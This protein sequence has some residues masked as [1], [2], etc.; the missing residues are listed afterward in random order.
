ML[1]VNP[2]ALAFIIEKAREFD[3]KVEPDDPE[4]GSNASDDKEIDILE[5]FADDPTLEELKSA[6]DGL[7]NDESRD[8]V[9]I[10]WTGRG[11][12]DKSS[13]HEARA[14]ANTIPPQDRSRYLCGTPLLAD[15]LEGGLDELEIPVPELEG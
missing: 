11:D 5:D 12:Y 15:Y 7:N 9:A 8:L 10:M 14:Q 1:S 4:S 6:I 3:A 13:W 2:E